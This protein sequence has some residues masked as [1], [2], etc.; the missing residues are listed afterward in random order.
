MPYAQKCTAENHQILKRN[1]ARNYLP[2]SVEMAFDR[3]SDCLEA[4]LDLPESV[5][6]G[7]KLVTGFF[8]REGAASEASYS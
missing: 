5:V 1:Q 8:E 7:K 4:V 6:A 3:E 2:V